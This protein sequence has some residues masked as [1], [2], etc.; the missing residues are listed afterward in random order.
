MRDMRL[1]FTQKSSDPWTILTMNSVRH[2]CIVCI[3]QA[4][5]FAD[6]RSTALEL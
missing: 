2:T 3:L 4:A 6:S 5:F 1:F